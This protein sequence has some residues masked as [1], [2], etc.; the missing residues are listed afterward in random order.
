VAGGLADATS[1][2]GPAFLVAA[3]VALLGGIGSLLLR[4]PQT[5]GA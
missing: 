1:S 4:P 5:M 3:G 2:F